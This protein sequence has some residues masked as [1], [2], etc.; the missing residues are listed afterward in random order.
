MINFT[1]DYNNYDDATQSAGSAKYA[2]CIYIR[3]AF[4]KF[5]DFFRIG[6]F[7]DSTH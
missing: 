4:I 6:I 5:P 1:N 3:G 2:N 7:I